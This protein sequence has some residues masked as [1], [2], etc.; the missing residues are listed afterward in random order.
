MEEFAKAGREFREKLARNIKKSLDNDKYR[1]E[2]NYDEV[3][4][5][6]FI[7]CLKERNYNG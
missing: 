2:K 6:N 4:M 3:E 7:H 5:H 1:R